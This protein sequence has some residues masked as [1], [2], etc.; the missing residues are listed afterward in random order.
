[1]MARKYSRFGQVGS[2]ILLACAV[3]TPA[4]LADDDVAKETNVEAESLPVAVA[5]QIENQFPGA[6][7]LGVSEVHVTY[8]EV[9]L[10]SASG[11]IEFS[12]YADG[13]EFEGVAGLREA[14]LKRRRDRIFVLC[15]WKRIRRTRRKSQGLRGQIG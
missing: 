1:M 6:K 9:E 15:R 7:I 4:T 11:E 14:L 10:E 12:F 2:A 5:S 8:Y 13:S 3:A